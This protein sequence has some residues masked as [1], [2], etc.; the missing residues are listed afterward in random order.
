MPVK[1]KK[2]GEK[3]IVVEASSGRKTPSSGSFSSRAGAQRQAN[4]INANLSKKGKI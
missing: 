1:P 3:W 4:A 2:V